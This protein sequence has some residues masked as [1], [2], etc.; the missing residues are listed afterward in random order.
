[1]KENILSVPEEI[2]I[3][4]NV[5]GK[6]LTG[7]SA[8]PFN[9]KELI[10]GWLY[11]QKIINSLSDIKALTMDAEGEKQRVWVTLTEDSSD[12]LNDYN[13]LQ[14]SACGGGHVR[15]TLFDNLKRI[16]RN[17]DMELSNVIALMKEIFQREVMFKK[18]GGIH[19]SM[20]AHMVK[21]KIL[22]SMEDIGRSN[23]VDKITGWALLKNI[24]FKELA[25]FTTG[26][27]TSDMIIKAYRAE[28]PAIISLTTFTS[29]SLEIAE[30][31][32]MTLGG[33]ILK[34]VPALVNF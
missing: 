34:P 18:H 21:N 30:R 9:Q 17:Y 26:R 28:I 1:M 13:P 7:M 31:A 12:N 19:C 2:I 29:R 11:N 27:I 32:G 15:D 14:T 5:N 16:K 3:T 24:K 33:Y 10:T 22:V 20:L 23:S 4:L 8:S 25:I 6:V